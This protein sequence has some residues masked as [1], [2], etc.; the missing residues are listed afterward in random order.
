MGTEICS[1]RTMELEYEHANEQLVT[2]MKFAHNEGPGLPHSEKNKPEKFPRPQIDQDSTSEAWDEF[3]TAW[4]QYKD[5]YSLTGTTLDRQLYA[6]CS[7]SLTI[8]L[9]R[10]TDGKH[11]ELGEE[12]LL[13]QIK[14][15]TT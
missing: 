15:L 14:K 4:L 9:S 10:I 3:H 6:Y 13:T 8:S 5:E 1:F 12:Q 11:F 7:Q 2:H